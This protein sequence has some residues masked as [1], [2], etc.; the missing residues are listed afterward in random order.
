[1]AVKQMIVMRKD[2]GMRRGKQIAQGAHASLAVILNAG[3]VYTKQTFKNQDYTNPIKVDAFMIDHLDPAVK[4]WIEGLFTKVCV[5]VDSEEELLR[6]YAVA[7]A[8]GIPCALITD[9]GLTEFNGVPTKT[10]CAIGP[11]PEE[12]LKPITGHLKLL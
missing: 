2:L 8:S 11:A 1:M 4:E 3:E 7:E 5:S 6:V 9:A 12:I 10:C